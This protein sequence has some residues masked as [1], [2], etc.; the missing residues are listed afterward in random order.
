MTGVI[1]NVSIALK[2][3]SKIFSEKK[4]FEKNIRVVLSEYRLRFVRNKLPF[5]IKITFFPTFA[6]KMSRVLSN[7]NG[8]KYS[9]LKNSKLLQTYI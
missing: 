7:T 4:I 1:K 3:T 2:N 8:M 5:G 9:K 6:R